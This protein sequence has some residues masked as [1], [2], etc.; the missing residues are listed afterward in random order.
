MKLHG[1]E[2]GNKVKEY[3]LPNGVKI[4]IWD[5]GYAGCSEEEIARRR[6]RIA[7]MGWLVAR[8]NE[9]RKLGLE[10]FPLGR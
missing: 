10:P 6:Q 1:F 9:L 2:M 5:G 7:E 3:R 4:E 8:N